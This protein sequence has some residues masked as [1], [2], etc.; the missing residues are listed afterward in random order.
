MQLHLKAMYRKLNLKWKCGPWDRKFSLKTRGHRLKRQMIKEPCNPSYIGASH[1]KCTLHFTEKP[2]LNYGPL[3][4][5]ACLPVLCFCHLSQSLY[6][7]AWNPI[8]T[9]R[10]KIFPIQLELPSYI[11]I[12][13]FTNQSEWVYS[14]Q[15]GHC[16]FDQSNCEYLESIFCFVYHF[17][18][19]RCVGEL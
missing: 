16:L 17:D 6:R 14:D 4:W 9:S 19:Y 5:T 11:P 15:S 18:N 10:T 1:T 12:G 7:I 8:S 13:F 3:H 2:V